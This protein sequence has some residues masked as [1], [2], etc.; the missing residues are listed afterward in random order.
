MSAH[1]ATLLSSLLSFVS[2]VVRGF[3]LALRS[4]ISVLWC[5]GITL[6]RWPP[7]H[8]PG[9]LGTTRCLPAAFASRVHI[10]PPRSISTLRDQRLADLCDLRVF[11]WP[12]FL[13]TLLHLR[14]T[15]STLVNLASRCLLRPSTSSAYFVVPTSAPVSSASVSSSTASS[16]GPALHALFKSFGSTI[17]D[18]GKKQTRGQTPARFRRMHCNHR[19]VQGYTLCNSFVDIF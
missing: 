18:P 6:Y 2:Q 16:L 13:L 10:D 7:V 5:N 19:V 12:C 11:M 17:S 8:C 15:S 9:H 3:R 1:Q 14:V 4:A